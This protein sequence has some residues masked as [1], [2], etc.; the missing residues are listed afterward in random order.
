MRMAQ[1]MEDV[2]HEEN[3]RLTLARERGILV[4]DQDVWLL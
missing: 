4:D 3:N 1:H 2:R